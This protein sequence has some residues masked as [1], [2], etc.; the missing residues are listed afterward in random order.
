MGLKRKSGGMMESAEKGRVVVSCGYS[1]QSPQTG[2]LETTD[3]YSLT[4]PE[5]GSPERGV[6]RDSVLWRL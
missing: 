1:N 2:W 6:C 5:A 4:V 3:V